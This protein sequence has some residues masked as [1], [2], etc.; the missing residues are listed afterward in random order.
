MKLGFSPR[1]EIDIED[2]GDYIFIDNPKAAI[3][4][5]ADLT[6]RCEKLQD[7]PNSGVRRP[8]LGE[9]IRFVPFGRY[10]I[11]YSSDENEIRIERVLHG[12]RDIPALYSNKE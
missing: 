2:I 3:K 1:S 7:A 12:A 5:I 8:E 6:A 4:F 10:L 11:F 9:A